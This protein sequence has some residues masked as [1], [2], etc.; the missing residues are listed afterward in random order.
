M[1][2]SFYYALAA[3][4]VVV[5]VVLQKIV[6]HIR[7]ARFKKQHGCK[8]EFRIPQRERIIGYGL[9]QTQ[10]KASKEKNMTTVSRQRYLDY[11]NTWS[12]QMMG[13]KFFNT[14]EPENLKHFLA[15][16][17][18]DFGLGR[19]QEAFGPLLGQG[20]FTTDGA[21]WEHS[22]ALVRP[23]FTKSQVADLDTFESHIQRLVTKI[24]RDG[25]T[26]DLQ[27]LFF[28]LTLDSATEFLFGESVNSLT[29][30]AGSEQEIFG[31]CFDYAQGQL[32]QRSRLGKL[33]HVFPDKEFDQACKTVHRFVDNIVFRALER[34]Q[35]KDAEKS[36]DGKGGKERYVFLT[37][38]MN[39]TRDPKQLRDELLNILLAGRDTTAS[40]LS[41]TFHVLARRP[42]IW[43]KLKAEVDQLNGEK[44]DY[45][46]LRNMKYLK[47]LLNESLRLYPVV[48]GNARFANRDTILPRGG[49][50]DGLSPIFVPK[51]DIVAWSTFSMHRRFDIYGPDALEFR[52]ERWAPEEN[53]R[54]GWGYLPF[55]GGPRICVG[56]QFALTEASYTTVRLLQEF[57][58]LED[59]DGSEWCEQLSLTCASGRGVKVALVPRVG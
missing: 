20:I 11:G 36:I 12:G 26:I 48:P 4:V 33:V 29:S 53:L 25:S 42:D 38:L 6:N 56:Q 31:R 46:T 21:Q 13:Q 59:R 7:V 3:L 51:G 34:S 1:A 37:E 15:T 39:S 28:Q 54:P 23:N 30:P 8:P 10:L 18:K 14:I 57:G 55:N 24:P 45:D 58:G 41:N 50:P 35:P 49:G 19:R 44:P 5:G 9:Y 16:D 17:F 2:F 47:Y 52:P 32:G 43:S 27:P 22:R 40:L